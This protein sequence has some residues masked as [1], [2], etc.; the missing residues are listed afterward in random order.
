M[1]RDSSS[2]GFVALA[3]IAMGACSSGGTPLPMSTNAEPTGVPSGITASATPIAEEAAVKPQGSASAASTA[4]TSTAAASA[5]AA[6]SA[7]TSASAASSAADDRSI[8][9]LPE[10]PWFH[11]RE[12]RDDDCVAPAAAMPRPHFPPPFAMCDPRAESYA[13]PPSG[14]S[15]HFHYRFFSVALT[16]EKR[17]KSPG[18]CCYMVWEFPRHH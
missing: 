1:P 12:D 9:A 10:E 6:S 8:A 7:A 2:V 17:A 11:D 13:S 16:A 5:S 18:V 14:S 4:A 3:I 15:L